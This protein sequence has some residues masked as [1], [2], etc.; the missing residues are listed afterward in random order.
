MTWTKR[1]TGTSGSDT[2]TP[3][4]R[5]TALNKP[6]SNPILRTW[7]Y[8]AAT[9]TRTKLIQPM[10]KGR[11][12]SKTWQ[13]LPDARLQTLKCHPQPPPVLP[14]QRKSITRASRW[15][16]P[17]LYMD[18]AGMNY[19]QTM[20]SGN[21]AFTMMQHSSNASV[22]RCS[23]IWNSYIQLL[24]SPTTYFTHKWDDDLNGKDIAFVGDRT[25]L[26]PTPTL[27]ILSPQTPWNWAMKAFT[28]DSLTLKH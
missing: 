1:R 27:V 21:E 2:S 28:L 18:T 17:L 12:T 4:T 25:S 13:P 16:Q 20:S 23:N 9:T 14:N 19:L 7:K 8:Q 3:I 15:R 11:I 24:H 22:V 5:A 10:G 6:R 26:Q